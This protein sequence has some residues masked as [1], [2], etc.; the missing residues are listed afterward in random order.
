[1]SLIF[2]EESLSWSSASK[3]MSSISSMI[4]LGP[5]ISV[6]AYTVALLVTS[7]TLILFTPAT[8]LRCFSIA[9]LQFAHVIPLIIN[10]NS[11][12]DD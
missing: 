12:V 8:E 3:P 2:R 10:F 4:F 5:M 7:D 11:F 6:S 9:L 1:M